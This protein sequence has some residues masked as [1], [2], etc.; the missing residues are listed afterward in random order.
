MTSLD[1]RRGCPWSGPVALAV[2]L[3]LALASAAPALAQDKDKADKAGS[4]FDDEKPAAKEEAKPKEEAKKDQA[5]PKADEKKADPKAKPEDPT[6]PKAGS[7]AD[8]DVIGFTQENAAGQMTEL[9]ERMFRLSEALRG[10]EP[11]NASRL[12]L[13]LKFS[14]EELILEQMRET[15]KLLKDA[16]LARAETE[17]RELLAKLQHLRDVLLAED[18]DFQLKLARLRQLRETI[19]QLD[20]LVNE[21]QREVGWTRFAIDQRTA[22]EKLLAAR[23]ALE[24]LARDH[25]AAL[26]DARAIPADGDGR[27]AARDGARDRERTVGKAAAALALNPVFADFQPSELRKVDGELAEAAAKLDADDPAAAV[28][29]AERG[30]ALLAAEVKALDA[31]IAEAE[32]DVAEPEFRRHGAGQ[33]RNRQAAATLG[34]GATRLGEIGVAVQKD[35]IRAGAAMET[36]EA[37]LIRADAEP[38]VAEQTAALDIIAQSADTVARAAEKLLVQLRTELQRRLIGEL[39]EGREAQGSIRETAAAQAPRLAQKSRAAAI[40][41][42]GLAQKEG[43]LGGKMETLLALIEECEYG[44]ALPTA[45]RVLGRE[46]RA[47][48]ARL[49]AADASPGCLQYQQRIEEGLVAAT[50]A[51]RRLPPTT[52]PP[53]GS[54]LPSDLRE[55]ERELNRL[56]AELK[57]VRLLQARLNDDTVVVDKARPNPSDLDPAVR[58]EVEALESTQEEIRDALAKVAE[59]IEQP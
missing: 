57:L 48:E 46:V 13:A 4:V 27:K 44:I 37:K 8:R 10:L 7:A 35:M 52:P 16:Q 53:P 34:A 6:K 3:G 30:A 40:A 47:A 23:P 2:A 5:R 15:N 54:P 24:A 33:A 17:V 49:K 1:P 22:R 29:A 26:A 18:L 43:E 11:E 19:G 36:A 56:V 59:R 58:R 39:T 38:A 21:E 45:V 41:V 25:A 12:R 55:R 42:A 50:Q 9:E 28:A 51:I 32:R 20:R 31:R 14:R